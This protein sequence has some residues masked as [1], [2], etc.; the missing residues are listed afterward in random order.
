EALSDQLLALRALLEPEGPAS[1]R[2]AGRV[3]ALCATEEERPV[4]TRRVAHIAGLEP[5]VIGGLAVDPAIDLLVGEL[6]GHLRA[7]L[8]DGL[9]APPQPPP[10]GARG[11]R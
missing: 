2:L 4:L 5:S 9:C 6:S 3:A 1:G 8:R 11:A 7:L 10:G